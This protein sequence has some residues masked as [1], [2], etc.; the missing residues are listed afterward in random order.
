MKL[1][2]RSCFFIFPFFLFACAGTKNFRPNRK[3]A[4]E[5]LRKDYTVFRHLLETWH[6][7]LYWYTTKDSMNRFFDEGWAAI[8]DSM[9]EEQFKVILSHV[10]AQVDCGHTSIRSSKGYTKYLDTARLT[11]FPLILKCWPDT[12]V[13]AANLNRRDTVL[14][15]GTVI[16]SIDGRTPQQLTDRLFPYI[17]TDGYN[18]TGKYQYLSTGLHFSSWYKEIFGPADSFDIDYL[19]TARTERET[20]IAL[21][22]PRTDTLRGSLG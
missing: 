16:L 14:R 9:T 10:I 12:M 18:L 15:R 11:Q 5:D 1:L 8:K 20:R 19:D 17:V 22:N 3:Y 21:Y 7:S 2:A 13:V 6:P 4:P